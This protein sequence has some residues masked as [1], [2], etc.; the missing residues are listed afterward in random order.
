LLIDPGHQITNLDIPPIRDQIFVVGIILMVVVLMLT[1]LFSSIALILSSK[2][3]SSATIALVAGM[4]AIIP[5]TGLIPTFTN[6]QAQ[7]MITNPV[8]VLNATTIPRDITIDFI[9]KIIDDPNMNKDNILNLFQN[10]NTHYEKIDDDKD[11]KYIK[12]LG[13]SSGES[14][15]YDSLF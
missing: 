4:G 5:I 13:V 6:K 1:L 15:V 9:K 8:S 10:V 2:I 14:D 12:N 7:T 11:N 3:S